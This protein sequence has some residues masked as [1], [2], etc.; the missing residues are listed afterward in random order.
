MSYIK[1]F[2][3]YI[4]NELTC[5]HAILSQ[6]SDT[7][8]DDN[9]SWAKE[10]EAIIDSIF[11]NGFKIGKGIKYT[12]GIY[13]F[14]SLSQLLSTASEKK[15]VDMPNYAYDEINSE[16]NAII[17]FKIKELDNFLILNKKIAL[18]VYSKFDL[19][20]QIIKIMGEK[21]TEQNIDKE[22]IS[23]LEKYRPGPDDFMLSPIK[24]F[25][26]LPS[27]ILEMRKNTM[28]KGWIFDAETYPPSPIVV[29]FDEKLI[30]PEEVSLDGGETWK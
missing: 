28:F 7:H 5:Y 6:H 21:W 14:Y 25:G 23:L 9:V 3:E 12:P 1:L 19:K 2:E 22:T 27:I 16:W 8:N 20:S 24:P 11:K 17:K 29:V 4:N 13:S 30:K 26:K 18:K 10:R 15:K